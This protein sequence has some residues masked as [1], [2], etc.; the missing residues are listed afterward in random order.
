MKKIP[1]GIFDFQTLILDNYYYVDKTNYLPLIEERPNYLFL[2]RPRRFGKSVFIN[3]MAAYY[4]VS[5]KDQFKT[6]FGNLWIGSH[7]TKCANAYQVLRFDFSRA[8]GSIDNLESKFNSYCCNV[9]N[10]FINKYASF[11]DEFTV[12]S[13]LESTSAEDKLN[14]IHLYAE[15][16]RYRL[17]LIID[18]YDNFTNDV[19]SSQG[20][21]VMTDLTHADGFYRRFFKLFKGAFDRIFMIGISPVT[22]DDITSGYNIDWNVSPDPKFNAML[23]FEEDEVMTM[24]E[25]Y[26][27]H[28]GFPQSVDRLIEMMKPWY[29]NYCFAEECYGRQTVY[30]CDMVLYFV[31]HLQQFGAA[32]KEMVDKNVRTDYSKLKALISLDKG[33]Q[34]NERISVIEE[35]AT[36]GSVNVWLQRSF[37]AM[38]LTEMDNFRSLLFYYGMLTI[39][40]EDHGITKMV[41]PNECVRMQYWSFLFKM[42]QKIYD[43]NF[44]MLRDEFLAMI[45]KGNW[46]PALEKIGEAYYA[47]S[48]VRDAIEGEHNVQG[49]FK[50]YLGQCNYSLLCPEMEL[51]Y[52]YSDFLMCPWRHGY[53]DAKHAYIIEIKYVKKD[54]KGEKADAQIEKAYDEA[55]TQIEQ[56]SS[57]PK[58]QKALVDCTLHGI[59]VIFHGPKMAVCEEVQS[60]KL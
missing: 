57:S 53:P 27:E 42:Y 60:L 36:K 33:I 58:L 29:D 19:L 59:I 34:Q 51:N 11:Y 47:T 13:V 17:Y 8:G 20:K 31:G 5:M 38:E 40:G 28:C 2:L 16:K 44:D 24:L 48:S 52:G 6:L 50:A 15:E 1:Y 12:K 23:G 35:V 46:R 41:I 54:N 37:P 7:P 55:K 18:E 3:M 14:I 25:Y 9:L 22:M 4:D 32:P 49:F 43:V 39:G 30:N 26:K 56:Y 10:R 45:I 21:E